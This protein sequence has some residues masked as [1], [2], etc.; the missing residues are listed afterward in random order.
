[1]RMRT[2]FTALLIAGLA[3]LTAPLPAESLHSND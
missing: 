1:M 3:A 2:F